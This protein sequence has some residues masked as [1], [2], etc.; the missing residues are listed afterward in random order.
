MNTF[1]LP[2]GRNRVGYFSAA[3]RITLVEWKALTPYEWRSIAVSIVGF[4]AAVVTLCLLHIENKLSDR[5]LKEG[6]L[7]PLKLQQVEI[8]EIFIEQPH[9]RKYF[10]EGVPIE[11]ESPSHPRSGGAT[12]ET[13][14]LIA[15]YC[16]TRCARADSGTPLTC[17]L[18]SG[19]RQRRRSERKTLRVKRCAA[20]L[21]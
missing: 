20:E 15:V 1:S 17:L 9:L 16:Q 6:A 3:L 13:V 11:R 18:F 14:S 8:D 4:A 21:F 2:P 10:Y 7:V 5:A 12:S 19:K